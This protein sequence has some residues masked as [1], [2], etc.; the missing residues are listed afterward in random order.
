VLLGVPLVGL[1]IAIVVRRTLAP[2]HRTTGDLKARPAL[3]AQPLNAEGAPDEVRPLLEA[4]NNLLERVRAG[5]E[6]E[7]TFITD[8]AH[9][10]RT[11]VTAL[12]LQGETL[13]GATSAADY[14]ERLADLVAGIKR[15]RHTL[16]QLLALARAGHLPAGQAVVRDALKVLPDAFQAA[17]RQRQVS[18]QLVLGDIGQACV[19]L[20]PEALGIVL[21]NLVDNALRYSPQG[22][23]ITVGACRDGDR[24]RIWVADQGPGLPE[25]ELE[26]VY[27][28][29]YRS[30]NDP[31]A[32]TGLG[33]S[34]VRAI[35]LAARGT[36]WLEQNPA[37]AG[38][39]AILQLPLI[40]PPS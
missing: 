21:Q 32:G 38:L 20:R 16:E 3:S 6:R 18:L 26:R 39:T 17:L 1:L 5:V 33:L 27:E 7:H 29:F 14:E 22:S 31:T 40:A 13:A 28:R 15:A 34:I 30:A 19:P 2:L 35:V 4:F 12:Q 23:T 36:T 11:P 9:A 25:D 10:L 37:G 8:A 24:C